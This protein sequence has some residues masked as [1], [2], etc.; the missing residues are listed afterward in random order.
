MVNF[1]AP[2]DWEG[3]YALQ[4]KA[5]RERDILFCESLIVCLGRGIINTYQMADILGEFNKRR[6]DQPEE[7]KN[8]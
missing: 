3:H 8:A 1:V 2:P 7:K 4:A 6:P 5:L